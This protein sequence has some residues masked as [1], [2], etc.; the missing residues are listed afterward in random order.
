[1]VCPPLSALISVPCYHFCCNISPYNFNLVIIV[2]FICRHQTSQQVIFRLG[3]SPPCFS[4]FGHC[5]WNRFDN[6]EAAGCLCFFVF[7]QMISWLLSEL[8]YRYDLRRVSRLY[9]TVVYRSTGLTSHYHLNNL[10]TIEGR[11]FFIPALNTGRVS[12]TRRNNFFQK[13]RGLPSCLGMNP[14]ILS[15]TGNIGMP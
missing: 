8:I 14:I 4:A 12:L 13:I 6:L 7:F 10:H 15:L 11:L 5:A 2:S 1:M 3:P 9:L